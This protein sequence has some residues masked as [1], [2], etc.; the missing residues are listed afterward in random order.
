MRSALQI[1][2]ETRFYLQHWI[3]KLSRLTCV[4]YYYNNSFKSLLSCKPLVFFDYILKKKVSFENQLAR[5]V[6]GSIIRGDANFC[7]PTNQPAESSHSRKFILNID[8]QGMFIL[9]YS[10]HVLLKFCE[11]FIL[12][13]SYLI[14]VEKDISPIMVISHLLAH[15][16]WFM[17]GT[18]QWC[19]H[20]FFLQEK[21]NWFLPE[22]ASFVGH[23]IH[24]LRELACMAC[25]IL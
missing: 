3:L 15:Y 12:F 17:D 24:N 18:Q 14:Y 10:S 11:H 20:S 16:T 1:W 13:L 23:W 5:V 7:W 22:S 6:S 8:L 9:T 21:K 2:I 25:S 4:A 19:E